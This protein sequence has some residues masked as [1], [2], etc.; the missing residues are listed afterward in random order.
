MRRLLLRAVL[1][2]LAAPL[3]RPTIAATPG[4]EGPIVFAAASLADAMRALGEAWRAD[5][6]P[7]PR[8]SFAA[9]SALARQMEQGAPADIFASADE[10]WMDY[11]A[12][13]GLI[14]GET[15]VSPVGNALVLIAPAGAAQAPVPLTPGTDLAALLGPSGRLATGDP[16]HVPA[17]R[18]AQAALTWMGQWGSLASRIARADNVRSA[19]L[20]VERGEAPLGIVYATDAAASDQVRV[21]GT[22]PGGSHPAIRYPFALTRRAAANG[23]ARAFLGFATGPG[24]AGTYRRLGFTLR[25]E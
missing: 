19:L 12:Q 11:A 20:L 14:L 18:Y 5:G 22:F 16:A 17:G 24:A 8:F 6:N 3:A 21:I 4:Q 10:A 13:R 7:V 2:G 1:A 9:S 15:R 25:A 23:H